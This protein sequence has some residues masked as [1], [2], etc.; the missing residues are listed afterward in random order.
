[1]RHL[2]MMIG[3]S[4]SG[5]VEAPSFSMPVV[6]IGNRQQ[7]RMKGK[8]VFDVGYTHTEINKGIKHALSWDRTVSC[9]H[10]Y[11]DGNASCKIIEHL[12]NVLSNYNPKQLISKKFINI[13]EVAEVERRIKK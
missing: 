3:N 11:G 5:L 1:M 13:K 9:F 10:P 6:N 2:S 8:N 7:G 4:S 12:R